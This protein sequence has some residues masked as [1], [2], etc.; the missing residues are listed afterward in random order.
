MSKWMM[1]RAGLLNFWYYD[2]EVFDFSDGKLLLR[3]S[4]GSGKSVTMQSFLP[5]LLDGKKSPDRLDPFGSKARRME[6]YLLGE[7][8]VVDR[9][10]RT[11]YL[12]LEYKKKDTNQYMTTGIGL[13]AKRNKPMKFWGFVIT[14]NRRIGFDLELYKTEKSG[15]ETEKI[16]RS[17]VELE[18][19]IG[20]GGHIVQTQK[21]YMAL[22]NKYIFGFDTLE[23]YEDLIK[24][25]IQLRSPKLSKDFR[26]TVIYEILEAA[27]PPLTDDDLRHLSDTIEQMDQTKQQIEQLEREWEAIKKV[28]QAYIQYNQRRLADIGQEWLTTRKKLGNEKK[29]LTSLQE[30]KIQLEQEIVQ[31]R[32]EQ[33]RLD[34]QQE[35]YGKKQERLKSHKIWNLEKELR[36]E[37][38]KLAEEEEKLQKTESHLSQL[39]RKEIQLREEKNK[40][41]ELVQELEQAITDKLEDMEYSVEEASFT[42]HAMNVTDYL[43]VRQTS[44]DF[45]VWKKEADNHLKQLTEMVDHFREFDRLKKEYEA[46]DME[47]A[48]EQRKLDRKLQEEKGWARLLEE[49]I[50]KKRGEIHEWVQGIAWITDLEKRLQ[51]SSRALQTLY[52]GTNYDQVKDPFR[53]AYLQFEDV[54]RAKRND[55][56]FQKEKLEEQKIEK[57]AELK[58][59]RD[60]KDPEPETAKETKMARQ[61]L[62]KQGHS[63]IPLYAAVEFHEHVPTEVRKRMESVLLDTGILDALVMNA[64]CEVVHDRVLT[65]NPVLLQQTL[66]DYLK[67]DPEV[68][69]NV[70]AER[71]DEV[72]RSIVVHQDEGSMVIHED[73]RYQIGLMKG[74]ALSYKEVRY[75]GRSAR[76]RYRLERIAEIETELATITAEISDV[77]L[78]IHAVDEEMA[79]GKK[80]LDSF[81]GD[82]DLKESFHQLENVKFIIARH[83]EQLDNLDQQVRAVYKD[84]LEKKYV[85]DEGAR[86]FDL[87]KT[88]ASYE[89][90]QKEMAYYKDELFGI[91]TLHTKWFNEMRRVNELTERIEEIM[92]QV[93]DLRG[94]FN[95]T[96][97]RIERLKQHVNQI[98]EQLQQEG[99][100]DIRKQIDEVERLLD[101][102]SQ[103]LVVVNQRLPKRETALSYVE[104]DIE[105]QQIRFEFWTKM[106]NAWA[107]SFKHEAEYHFVFPKEDLVDSSELD[108]AE[109]AKREFGS[110][111]T[112]KD[113]S[114]IDGYLTSTYYG[115]YSDLMEYRMN[116]YQAHLEL[117][118][119][120]GNELEAEYKPFVE[121]WGQKS[122]RRIIDL[123]YQG[124]RVSPFYI[125]EVIE[126]DRERQENLLDEQD[127][128]LYEDILFK[129][130][131]NK[132]RSR[133]RRAKKWTKKM[134]HLMETRDTSSGLT[135]SI[136]WKPRTAEVEEELDT[137]DL[138]DLLM[139]DPR[140]LKEQDLQKITGH[141]R[142]KIMNAKQLLDTKTEGQTL[143]QVLKEVLDYRK[144]FSF[145]L[146][147]RREN[148]PKRELTNYAFYKFSGGEKAMAMYIPLFTACY[149][150]YQEADEGAPYII[151]L[152]EAFA[153]VDENNIREMFEIV[154]HLGFNY[155]MNSQ[156]LWGDYDTISKLAICELVRP[157]N[158][159][160]V[161]VINY[162]WDGKKLSVRDLEAESLAAG[163]ENT[164]EEAFENV[165]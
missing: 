143:L 164:D 157:K 16:P 88:L 29:E 138:V 36:G 89:K 121:L 97:D 20:E 11:G 104:R 110:L 135:F 123:D 68:H 19:V 148:E 101:R 18:T 141:F 41:E 91:E 12:F 58:E 79:L 35:V 130:V 63:F 4:N 39:S 73:G 46:K 2:E 133:I 30:K 125:Q 17:R 102:I 47:R 145:V 105:S 131:G 74:H 113:A 48:E 75:I 161:S 52:K 38:D 117:P 14:D 80:K 53:D 31:T 134:D 111:V 92:Y 155:I 26:P 126:K 23:A 32:E 57:E 61:E 144:W 3:G 106:E 120:M 109:K 43:R 45:T 156:V 94:E 10:E 84:Y 132:L 76:K 70:S 103:E 40:S 69:S 93:D 65:S 129:S 136:R 13:Q 82:A 21:E 85:I 25:L 62:E 146:S 137:N 56:S 54:Q 50:E 87:E 66:G 150:R 160:F 6:D 162:Q 81:P 140:L 49:D 64:E 99:A 27:L 152:D 142:S 159:D 107:H 96:K 165:K 115:Q 55:L 158:A 128:E 114:R 60:R 119:W 78:T 72:L 67:P 98:E 1:N 100:D 108:L 95:I 127:Q 42:K 8:E 163:L 112:E 7:K 147:Y 153:G 154:E 44:F 124:K 22:V 24:L 86:Q 149:S 77:L 122:N 90:A 34:Q 118:S 139:Q 28:N 71:V 59:W 116:D 51:Q 33:Q 37:K 151:S 9:D 83:R 5:V 15:G